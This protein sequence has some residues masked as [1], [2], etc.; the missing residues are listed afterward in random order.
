M[1]IPKSDVSLILSGNVDLHLMVEVL[2]VHGAWGWQKRGTHQLAAWQNVSNSKH[3]VTE[4]G[5]SNVSWVPD[6]DHNTNRSFVLEV[7]ADRADSR[8]EGIANDS[9]TARDE[10]C[11]RNNIG[12]SREVDDFAVSVLSQD[13]VDVCRVICLTISINGTGGYRFD[14]QN[15][16]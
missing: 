15:L 2:L 10:D 13:F 12:T 3:N 9:R 5:H 14:I 6:A 11:V 7:T 16:V 8:S 1:Y 4:L